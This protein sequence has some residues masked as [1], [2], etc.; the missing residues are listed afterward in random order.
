MSGP[1]GYTLITIYELKPWVFYA[2]NLL[3]FNGARLNVDL[4]RRNLYLM[5]YFC[6]MVHKDIQISNVVI[7]E[8]NLIGMFFLFEHKQWPTIVSLVT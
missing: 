2:F 4:Y 8:I 5:K 1:N 3:N 6:F 7:I